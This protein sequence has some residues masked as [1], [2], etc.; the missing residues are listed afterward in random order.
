MAQVTGEPQN[1][2]EAE[3]NAPVRDWALVVSAARKMETMPPRVS[4]G[5]YDNE[6]IEM[7]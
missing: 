4:P 5:M 2:R 7:E 6:W 1:S 3:V